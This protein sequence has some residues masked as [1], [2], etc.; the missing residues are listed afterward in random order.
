V[1]GEV[2]AG[3]AWTALRIFHREFLEAQL[4][5]KDLSMKPSRGR[6]SPLSLLK[7]C[8]AEALEGRTLLTTYSVTDLGALPGG[9]GQSTA[10]AINNNG[11]VVGYSTVST[12]GE[13]HPFIYTDGK[14]QDINPSGGDSQAWGVNDTGEV[15]GKAGDAFLYGNGPLHSIGRLPG[16]NTSFAY[17]INNEGQIAGDSLTSNPAITHAFRFNVNGQIEDLGTLGGD[18]SNAFGINNLGDV[19]GLA[20]ASD[21]VSH[22]FLYTDGHMVDIGQV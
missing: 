15:V 14:L 22:A 8:V 19:V 7:K 17:A 1:R 3:V 12:T 11:Q 6:R 2:A 18:Q 16:G 10:T 20:Y 4:V 13:N 5:S 9:T 21:G